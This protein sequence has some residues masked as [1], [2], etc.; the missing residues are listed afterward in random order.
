MKSSYHLFLN[1]PSILEVYSW[2]QNN[3]FD[4]LKQVSVKYQH[5]CIGK[6]AQVLLVS[7]GFL[8]KFNIEWLF[9]FGKNFKFSTQFAVY[10]QT[11]NWPSSPVRCLTWHPYLTKLAI[12]TVDDSVRILSTSNCVQG[13]IL[14]RPEQKNITCLAW[15]PFTDTDLAVACENGIIIWSIAAKSLMVIF[16]LFSSFK[17]LHKYFSGFKFNGH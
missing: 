8:Q 16:Q 6:V 9:G 4:V 10:S 11:K 1:E 12:A 5:K 2:Y 7:N 3:M 15:R 17:Y 14:R 13:P